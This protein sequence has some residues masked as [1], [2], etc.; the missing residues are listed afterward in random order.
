[1]N[2]EFI[3]AW[4][5]L[6][7]GRGLSKLEALA[8]ILLVRHGPIMLEDLEELQKLQAA[9]RLEPAELERLA[10]LLEPKRSE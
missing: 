1:M 9:D 10:E 8:V 2:D 5:A 3:D 7:G 6:R 4:S